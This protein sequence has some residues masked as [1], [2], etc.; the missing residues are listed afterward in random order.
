MDDNTYWKNV[1]RGKVK[2]ASKNNSD[3]IPWEIKTVDP[4]LKQF[5]DSIDLNT[6]ELLELGSGS[7]YDSVYLADHGFDVTAIDVSEDV[8][9]L[10]KKIHVN[11]K[12][13]F[14][15]A[16]FFQSSTDKKFDVIYDR[17]F[18][19]NYKNRL[20]EIFE[21]LNALLT[22]NG[23][24]IIITGSPCQPIIE[25]CMPPPI[26]LGEIEYYSSDFFKIVLAKEVPFI[27]DANFEN[28]LGYMFVLEKINP[29]IKYNR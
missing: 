22:D 28:C 11:S 21:K 13:N 17:G 1:Y 8:I 3:V 10:S 6:G 7:G 16:D 4:N 2:F 24:L 15:A 12:V 27:T 9:E 14:I 20:Q 29:N 5:L 25:S 23:K 26:F 18:L 19:H